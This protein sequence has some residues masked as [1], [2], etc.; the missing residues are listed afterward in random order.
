MQVSSEKTP[1]V[2]RK[3]LPQEEDCIKEDK[4]FF[5][6]WERAGWQQHPIVHNDVFEEKLMS[7]ESTRS[8]RETKQFRQPD[9]LYY[10]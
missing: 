6:L 1:I 5:E 4:T 7:N 10:K 9:M 3:K 8:T 2:T